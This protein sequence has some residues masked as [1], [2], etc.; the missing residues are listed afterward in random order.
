[1][2]KEGNTYTLTGNEPDWFEPSET[3]ADV[4]GEDTFPLSV[5]CAFI[6]E[7]GDVYFRTTDGRSFIVHSSANEEHS[8]Y[9]WAQ[10]QPTGGDFSLANTHE[11]ETPDVNFEALRD[12]LF[13]PV[14]KPEHYNTN[15]PE[16]I[17]VLDIIAAQTEN[18][19]GLR[20]FCHANIIK[21][22]LRWQKKNGVE[23]LKKART[24]IDWLIEE[25]E[26]ND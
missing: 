23:D 11:M 19:S 22:A 24:Y 18:L 26:N 12:Y 4:C 25:V 20:A 6:D 21:Y 9:F 14:Q 1:M 5:E 13:D 15:L 3:L 10:V 7:V 2:Y 8:T 17:E 16:G